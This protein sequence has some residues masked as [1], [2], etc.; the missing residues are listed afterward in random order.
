MCAFTVTK[1]NKNKHTMYQYMRTRAHARTHTHTTRKLK[2]H[3]E[4]LKINVS[5]LTE[6]FMGK[7]RSAC[8]YSTVQGE[9]LIDS[10]RARKLSVI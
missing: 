1:I 5:F 2:V 4:C 7:K 3:R 6:W 9:N 8:S 10:T